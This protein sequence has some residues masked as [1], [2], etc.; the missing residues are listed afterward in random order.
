[1]LVILVPLLFAFMGFAI[2]LG[3]LYLVRGELKAAADAM[4]LAAAARLTGTDAS[5]EDA[6][7]AGQLAVT[8]AG[9]FA[10]RYDFG[11]LPIG[12]TSGRLASEISEPEYFD[13]VP[14]AS[15]DSGTP[16]AGGAT[17]RHVRIT[18]TADAPL[19]FWSFLPL[20]QDRRTPV[21]V[22]A[23]AGISA[24][25]CAACGIEAIAVAA[26]DPADTEHFGFVAA[27][28]YTLGYVCNGQGA[29]GALPGTIQRV[30][31][32]LINRLDEEAEIFTGEATQTFRIGAGGLPSSTVEARSCVLVDSVEQV[33]STATPLTCQM[34]QVPAQVTGYVCGLNSRLEPGINEAC[35]GI[36]EIDAATAPFAPDT[37]LEDVA[38][39]AAYLG[40]SR[41]V[42]T[43]PI[44]DSLLDPL[45]MTVLGFRQFLLQPIPNVGTLQPQ[46]SNGRFIVTYI[47][48]PVPLRQGRFNGCSV[49]S[50]PGRV[51][52][53]Q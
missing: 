16:S 13:T 31:Y 40:N 5:L 48:S 39:Y 53:H 3:R 15:G 20:A 8:E 49:A 7:A 36:P 17:A 9:G 25:L 23:L 28:R 6:R 21:R 34:N 32:L 42:L 12:E 43:I 30:P 47:G 33:W 41:R 26:P 51:V 2:D 44:V 10:N 50:G 4:A 52:L 22:S 19:A 38:D 45:A 46:D 35:A 11:G 14:G 1:M 37:D 24:P 27:E 18:L 29:P